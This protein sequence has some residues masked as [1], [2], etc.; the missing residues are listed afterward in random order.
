MLEM[1]LSTTTIHPLPSLPLQI[2]NKKIIINA[3]KTHQN[4]GEI[5]SC[6]SKKLLMNIKQRTL[7]QINPRLE[8]KQRKKNSE[9]KRERRVQ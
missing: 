5:K 9:A 1:N 3:H 8:L 4:K 2:K 7:I 6:F